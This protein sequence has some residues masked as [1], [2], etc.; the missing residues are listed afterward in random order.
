M[1][2]VSDLSILRSEAVKKIRN[3]PRIKAETEAIKKLIADG[4]VRNPDVIAY[5]AKV[6]KISG[7]I[8]ES[9]MAQLAEYD[10]ISDIGSEFLAPI[11]RAGQIDMNTVAKIAQKQFNQSMGIGLK[12]ADVPTDESR[13]RHIEERYEKAKSLDEVKF[14]AGSDVSEN[15]YKSQVIKSIQTNAE[16][17]SKAGFDVYVT[18]S[19]GSGCCDWCSGLV[20]TYKLEKAPRDIWAAHKGCSCSID[21][22]SERTGTHTRISFKTDSS[23]N[24]SKNVTD[25]NKG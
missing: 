5:A 17:H 8:L 9:E 10:V 20:G 4:A 16:Q 7:S 12:P 15:I 19:D 24:I 11:Y 18:R 13:I 3:D 1:A 22:K 2:K 21:Y 25:L 23:G 6:G 14:L